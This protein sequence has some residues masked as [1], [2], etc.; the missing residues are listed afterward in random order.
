MEIRFVKDYEV[1]IGGSVKA[2]VTV[3]ANVCVMAIYQPVYY[4]MQ[5]TA[6]QSN[7]TFFCTKPSVCLSAVNSVSFDHEQVDFSVAQTNT[8]IL[9]ITHLYAPFHVSC[10]FRSPNLFSFLPHDLPLCASRTYGWQFFYERNSRRCLEC[11]KCGAETY[12]FILWGFT[13]CRMPSRVG[14]VVGVI[15]KRCWRNT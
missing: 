4:R 10:V 12:C 15:M 14:E 2:S 9:Y 8:Y 6:K 11:R 5:D 1:K 13:F 7:S 3:S